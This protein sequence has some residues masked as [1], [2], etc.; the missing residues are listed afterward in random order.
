MWR[1]VGASA[2]GGN[3]ELFLWLVDVGDWR[4]GD[5]D[6]KWIDDYNL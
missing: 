1:S 6:L 5:M 3:G 4:L 2:V